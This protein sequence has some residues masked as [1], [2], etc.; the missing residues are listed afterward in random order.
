MPERYCDPCAERSKHPTKADAQAACEAHLLDTGH[1]AQMIDY[2]QGWT[3]W[4]PQEGTV[5]IR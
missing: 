3:C 1:V 4:W 2:G 5:R